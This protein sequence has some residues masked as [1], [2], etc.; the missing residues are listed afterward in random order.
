MNRLFRLSPVL[1]AFSLALALASPAA[2][3]PAPKLLPQDTLALVTVSDWGRTLADLKGSPAG[4]LWNDPLLKPFRDHFEEKFTGKILGDLEKE[5]GIKA[6]DYLGLLQGQFTV[7]LVQNDWKG[8]DGTDPGWLM[9]I[10]TKERSGDLKKQLE[11]V[12]KKLTDAKKPLKSEKI[13]DL[14]FS[15]LTLE[16]PAKE[17]EEEPAEGD[18]KPKPHK[19]NLVFGQADTALVLGESVKSVE[20]VVARLTGGSVPTVGE[21]PG[22]QAAEAAWFGK[23]YVYGWVN[24]TPVYNVLLQQAKASDGADALGVDVKAALKAVGLAGL[25]TVSFAA[26]LNSEGTGGVIGLAVPEA[27]RV[28]LFKMLAPTAKESGPLPFIPADAV[29]FT[30]WRI[31]GQKVWATLEETL[32]NVSPQLAGFVQRMISTAGK[33]KDPNFDFKKTFVANLGDD[34][35]LYSKAPTGTSPQ[36]LMSPPSLTLVGSANADRLATGLRAAG[37]FLPGSG[38]E[39]KDREFNGKKVGAVRLP[40]DPGQKPRKLEIAASGGYV[41]VG[42]SPALLEEY[43][44][45]AEGGGKSLRDDAAIGRAAEKVGGLGTGLFGYENQRE[46]LRGQWEFLR[47]GGFDKML[48]QGGGRNE[49]RE[50]FDFK[51]LPPYDQIAKHFGFAVFA[52]STDPQGLNFKFYGPNPR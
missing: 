12:R 17:S 22:F 3:P 6:G 29:T 34:L 10:D 25:K 51:A 4:H 14:D 21:D 15:V 18:A 37:G 52:G 36:E 26:D 5:L 45:S 44:R 13:R 33:D 8:E 16:L 1:S 27:Q 30:R 41:A 48:D 43:L 9:I 47:T 20:K 28:G 11:E 35:I 40:S 38:E 2:V 19:M 31:D 50:L 7:A 46:S 42:S 24:I 39:L 49:W 23:A 32:G